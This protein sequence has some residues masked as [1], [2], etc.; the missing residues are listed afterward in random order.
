MS[1]KHDQIEEGKGCAVASKVEKEICWASSQATMVQQG[2]KQ[3]QQKKNQK[4]TEWS[5]ERVLRQIYANDEV[6]RHG[7]QQE[8][9]Q[10]EMNSQ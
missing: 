6:R 4:R 1:W 2:G 5:I 7:G 8:S 9:Y 10:L 3:E